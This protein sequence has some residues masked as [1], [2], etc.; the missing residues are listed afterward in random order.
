MLQFCYK[1]KSLK[2][3]QEIR[4]STNLNN[5]KKTFLTRANLKNA[6]LINYSKQKLNIKIKKNRLSLLFFYEITKKNYVI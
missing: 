6:S 3:K 5:K 1:I 4:F 2:K